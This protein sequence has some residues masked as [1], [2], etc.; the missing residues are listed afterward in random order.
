MDSKPLSVLVTGS[1]GFI[2]NHVV[3]QHCNA[4]HRVIGFDLIPPEDRFPD[5]SIYL[6]GDS[7]ARAAQVASTALAASKAQTNQPARR[8]KRPAGPQFHSFDLDGYHKKNKKTP[9]QQQ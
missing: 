7:Q 5:G 1:S 8:F 6:C 9:S 3:R 4:G 2:G